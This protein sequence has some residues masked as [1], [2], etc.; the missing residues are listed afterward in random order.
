MNKDQVLGFIRHTLTFGGGY[1]MAK[2]VV[3]EVTLNTAV[4]GL[5]ALAG[6]GWSWID[7]R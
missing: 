7:K 2:G 1:L 6:L 3:D 5:V 4:T